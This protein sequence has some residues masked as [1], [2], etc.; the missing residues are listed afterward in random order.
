MNSASSN[1]SQRPS[2]L[3]EGPARQLGRAGPRGW[4]AQWSLGRRIAAGFGIIL[5]LVVLQAAFS[6]RAL[7]EAD[8]KV[9]NISKTSIPALTLLDKV[10]RQVSEI[11]LLVVRCL[12]TSDTSVVRETEKQV[13]ALRDEVLSLCEQYRA[14]G[15]STPKEKEAFRHMTE[16]RDQ[17]VAS[18]S[19]LFGMLEA[20]DREGAQAFNASIFRAQYDAYQKSVLDIVDSETNDAHAA[21]ASTRSTM[22]LAR[23]I[24]LM[25]AG[26]VILLGVVFS[27]FLVTGISRTLFRIASAL[28]EGAEQV[29]AASAQVAGSSHTLAEGASEQAA[30]LEETGSS[31]EEMS[32]M[33]TRNS[34]S[35][36]KASV[37]ARS[38][39][40]SA[41]VGAKGMESMQDA[42]AAIKESSDDIAK[43]VK[44]IDEIAFQT[45]ILALNAAVEAARAGSAGAGFAVVADEVRALAQRSAESAKQTAAKIEGAIT[46]SRQGVEIS[47]KVGASLG[48]IVEKI[49]QVD[50]LIAEVSTASTEQSQGVAQINLAVGE[51]DRVVQSNAANAEEAASAAEELNGQAA[52]MR[53]SVTELLRLVQGGRAGSPET[54]PKPAAEPAPAA[55]KSLRAAFLRGNPRPAKASERRVSRPAG[56]GEVL[57]A[58]MAFRDI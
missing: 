25:S 57:P 49:R 8:A 50:S 7:F 6:A 53:E 17:Y 58:E 36:Q 31:L 38:S 1:K 27:V 39:R 51:M 5:L 55:G 13:A 35:A 46:K 44:T 30:S 19:K 34:E 26:G 16:L 9:S 40:E 52:T 43:I 18:R 15:V 10:N 45:N 11:H 21:A 37:L 28:G 24:S 22:K 41:E 42:M 2:S 32:S 3:S 56:S 20:G 29:A 23:N 54:T 14:I 47:E 12:L 48:S 4:F 33:T